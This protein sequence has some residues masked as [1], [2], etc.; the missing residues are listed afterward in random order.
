[1]PSCALD[2]TLDG[3]PAA[4]RQ[5]NTLTGLSEQRRPDSVRMRVWFCCT[6]SSPG[7]KTST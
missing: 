6:G 4:R 1:M 2:T 3:A 5:S 7:L